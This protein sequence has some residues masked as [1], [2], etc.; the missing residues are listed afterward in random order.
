MRKP[1]ESRKT[2]DSP[3][4]ETVFVRTTNTCGLF[5]IRNDLKWH[6]YEP[7]PVMRGLAGM[8]DVG[9]WDLYGCLFG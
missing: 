6:G 2:L 4:T 9:N 1:C 8:L 7:N 5:W 3:L